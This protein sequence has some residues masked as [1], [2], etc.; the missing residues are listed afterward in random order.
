MGQ[1]GREGDMELWQLRQ[2]QSLPLEAKILKSQLR[3]R[4]WYEA[5]DGKVYLSFSGGKDSTVLLHLVR[6]IYPDVPAVFVDTGLEFPEI[7]E[8]VRSVDNVET[9]RPKMGFREVIERYG[10]PVISKQQADY[11]YQYT[12]A[13]SEKTKLKRL[14]GGKNGI[15]KISECWKYL[16]TAPFKISAECCHYM[17]KQPSYRYEKT[18]SRKPFMGTMADDGNQ[19][20]GQYLK[21]GCNAFEAKRPKSTPLGFW[22]EQDIWDY[23]R[24]YNIPYSSIYDMGYHRTGCIFCMFGVHLEDEPNRFQR[25]AITHPKL[26]EYCIKD[27]EQGGLGLGKVLDYINVPYRVYDGKFSGEYM[28]LDG[29]KIEQLKMFSYEGGISHA[30]INHA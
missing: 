10:Y 20:E 17:K 24:T 12:H 6:S 5:W 30:K 13:K 16:I 29:K 1:K 26:Y 15:G 2:M 23:I 7:K 14:Y 3:I 28:K 9:L 4:E 18:S 27:W 21:H 25:L 22:L 8:F 19:R 11:I